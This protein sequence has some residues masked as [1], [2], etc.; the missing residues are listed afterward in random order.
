[1]NRGIWHQLGAKS[2]ILALEHLQKGMG[3]GVIISE[4]DL[5][6][7]NAKDYA[8]RYRDLN[9]EILVDHQFYN[10]NFRHP[11]FSTFPE[12]SFRI[13]PSSI[14][15]LS[16]KQLS[17]LSYALEQTLRE[18]SAT[19]VISP[20]IKY[21]AG[22]TEI[23]ETNLRLFTAAR[24]V[25]NNLGIPTYATVIIDQSSTDSFN[26]VISIL[27]SATSLDCDGW[28]YGFEFGEKRIPA[29]AEKVEMFCKA[30]L[31][32]AIT[33]KPVLHAFAGPMSILSFA[34]GSTGVAL[35]HS[36][37]LWQFS[38]ERWQNMPPRKGPKKPLRRLFSRNLWGTIVYP[39]EVARLTKSLRQQVL[40]TSDYSPSFENLDIPWR[41]GDADK[42]LVSS[43]CQEIG[44][45]AR[46]GSAAKCGVYAI[47]RLTNANNFYVQI[48][49]VIPN[50]RDNANA[51]HSNWL[52]ALNNLKTQSKDDLDY[53]AAIS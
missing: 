11:S 52:T 23:N 39:N 53:F 40:S 36:H 17:D 13:N 24:K 43:I 1:M 37:N 33:G 35:G 34:F 5:K 7:S 9:A 45:I 16:E 27:S 4:K 3:V 44:E 2:Q 14:N 19:G 51:Y 38:S 50:L 22:R 15:R 46:L 8:Q 26:S 25:G 42:H 18:L 31:K 20:A 32:L 29:S 10:S 49:S 47:G 21:Q 48:K 12:N 6:F 30:G 41:K 28:Y